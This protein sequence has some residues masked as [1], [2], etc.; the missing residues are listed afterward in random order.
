LLIAEKSG[1]FA[2]RLKTSFET[3]RINLSIFLI[4]K[5]P[6]VRNSNINKTSKKTP[7]WQLKF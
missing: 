2:G 5:I 6:W 7:W 4:L 1:L 3:G